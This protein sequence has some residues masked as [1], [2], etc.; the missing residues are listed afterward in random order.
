MEFAPV[1]PMSLIG[2]GTAAEVRLFH[3]EAEVG[4]GEL[5]YT[6]PIMFSTSGASCGIAYFDTV[7][8]SAYEAPFPFTGDL[9][10]VVLDVSGELMVNPGAEVTR[11]M[12]QQ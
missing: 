5:P 1:G 9:E 8:P 2:R 7:D 11:M 12:T 10:K 6:V 4:F 3:D